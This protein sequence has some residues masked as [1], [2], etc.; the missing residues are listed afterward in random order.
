[1]GWLFFLHSL[2]QCYLTGGTCFP[3]GVAGEC[4]HNTNE[5]RRGGGDISCVTDLKEA[6]SP[7]TS[8]SLS[9][10]PCISKMA[11]MMLSTLPCK[12]QALKSESCRLLPKTFL[13]H[14]RL[15]PMLPVPRLQHGHSVIS[16]VGTTS[17]RGGVRLPR[18]W[19]SRAS[20]VSLL[21][22]LHCPCFQAPLSITSW[23]EPLSHPI[24]TWHK[25]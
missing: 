14:S 22:T 17:I 16:E 24:S 21:H 8:V 12:E 19:E 5:L 6:D 9:N 18:G 4:Y 23:G 20:K 15:L 11:F 13:I 10:G 3:T 2:V 1:M 25:L 7:C